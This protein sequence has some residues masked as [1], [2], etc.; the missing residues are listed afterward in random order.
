MV[1]ITAREAYLPLYVGDFL[2]A[3]A[4]WNGEEQGL[5]LLLLAYQ[6]SIGSLP[7]DLDK[8]AR[9]LRWDRSRLDACWPQVGR[10]FDQMADRLVNTRLEEHRE[11]A[12]SIAAKR[13]AAG[14]SGATNRWQTDG[15][16]HDFAN[17]KP[18]ANAMILPLANGMPSK[19]N[20]PIKEIG[21]VTRSARAQRKTAMPEDFIATPERLAY[22][23]KHLPD[24]DPAATFASFVEKAGAAGLKY[25]DWDRAMQ[26]WVRQWRPGSQHFSE[27]QYPRRTGSRRWV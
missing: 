6:W 18:M 5:Y 8:L 11:R 13:S 17:G 14:K 22:I 20:K 27:G 1:T 9:M 16:C 4:E 7:A 26:V 24:A 15:N 19:P 25:A 23:A 10:K 3:T 21:D 2:A 12:R